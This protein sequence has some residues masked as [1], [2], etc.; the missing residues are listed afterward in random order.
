[1]INLPQNPQG[2][3]YVNGAV[4]LAHLVPKDVLWLMEFCACLGFVGE[5]RGKAERWQ[6]LDINFVDK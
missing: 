1:M 4:W 2:K 3:Y 6:T 5:I